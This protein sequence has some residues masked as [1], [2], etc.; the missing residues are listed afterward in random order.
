MY[1][2]K[3]GTK[4]I[5]GALFCQKCGAKL[6]RDN[7]GE[8][9]QRTIVQQESK[10][11]PIP[12][13][14]PISRSEQKSV[15]EEEPVLENES[16]Q[17]SV[18]ESIEMPVCQT[19]PVIE[20]MQKEEALEEPLSVSE[21]N[22][23]IYALLEENIDKCPIARS[24]K[25]VKKGVRLRGKIFSHFVRL[26]SV[27]ADQIRMKSILAI[28]FSVLYG[29]L[30]C[31]FC[32]LAWMILAEI[33]KYGSI[34]I[35]YYHGIFFALCFLSMGAVLLIHSFA[36][37]KEK[38]EDEVCNVLGFPT[39]GTP[40]NGELLF[41]G[42]EYYAYDG[43]LLYF[44]N[45]TDTVARV[46][47]QSD[48]V[49]INGEALDKNRTELISLLGQPTYEGFYYDESG[50]FSDCY[51]MQYT[52]YEKGVI[53]DIEMPDLTESAD[54]VTI[55]EYKDGPED[56]GYESYDDIPNLGYGLEWVEAPYITTDELGFN[57]INGVIENTSAY[58]KGTVLIYF[59]F[60]T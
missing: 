16:N 27:R 53:L 11:A 29:L 45:Q 26:S 34:C 40:I 3:C 6:V 31:L 35:E 36:G 51:Y 20:M 2:S 17:V 8:Q 18:P 32:I 55:Y 21:D 7:G 23:D 25:R 30:I 12:S 49:K 52:L 13:V 58:T 14:E 38:D 4:A 50:E 28:P 19:E 33:M 46:S 47:A 54:S 41:G 24:A 57:V 5:D 44:D 10:E 39:D 60:M 59:D 1:C 42:T 9:G 56:D 22:E 37:C 43:L 48:F 15:R